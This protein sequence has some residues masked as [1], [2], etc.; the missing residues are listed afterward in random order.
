MESN[1]TLRIKDPKLQIEYYE[2]RGKEIMTISS[3][4]ATCCIAINVVVAIISVILKWDE[5]V[6][7]LWTGRIISIVLNLVLIFFQ[8]KYPLQVTPFHGPCLVV[9]QLGFFLWGHG[10]ASSGSGKTPLNAMPA[11]IAGL[12]TSM[13]FGI[14]CSAHWVYT[15]ISIICSV[16]VTMTYYSIRFNY[17][18]YAT[19]SLIFNNMIFLFIALYKIEKRDKTDILQYA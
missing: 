11:S 8:Y 9:S 19:I 17:I 15:A 14:L 16:L 5:Y 4:V 3:L 13:V 7:E 6:V 12:F 10:D 1:I 2:K 18:D